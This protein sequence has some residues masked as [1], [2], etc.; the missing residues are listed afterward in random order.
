MIVGFA[1]SGRGNRKEVIN[2]HAAGTPPTALCIG[3]RAAAAVSWVV[4]AVGLVDRV[5]AQTPITSIGP[6][7]Q[8]MPQVGELGMPSFTIPTGTSDPFGGD[9]GVSGTGLGGASDGGS[10]SGGTLSSSNALNTML[11][12]PWGITA[13][14]YAEALGI[15]PSALAATCVLESGCQNMGGSGSIQGAFQMLPSTYNS[16]MSAALAQN[17]SLASSIVPGTAGMT[18]PATE[19]VAASEYLLQGAQALQNANVANPTVLDVRG[20]YNFGPVAGVALAQATDDEPMSQMLSMYTSAQLAQNGINSE[21]TVGQW[22][23]S[24]TAKIGNAAG[25]SVLKG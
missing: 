25:Q 18:D 23:A 1:T 3:V 6:P 5:G 4:I 7:P 20:Y 12:Q 11:N 10:G 19:S 13:V 15:N 21:E 9:E 22:R 2:R 17:P 24:V 14:N 16:M 8:V